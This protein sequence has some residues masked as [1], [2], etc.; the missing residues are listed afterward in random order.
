MPLYLLVALQVHLQPLKSRRTC[1]HSLVLAAYYLSRMMT[2]TSLQEQGMSNSRAA[3]EVWEGTG[4]DAYTAVIHHLNLSI[5]RVE[6]LQGAPRSLSPAHSQMLTPTCSLSESHVFTL[7]CSLPFAH[8]QLLTLT[9]SSSNAHSHLLTLNC[10]FPTA[11]S[12]MR[13][14]N[15]SLSTHVDVKA[16]AVRPAAAV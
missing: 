12:Q 2:P 7:A 4:P 10:S 11:H 15:C 3:I 13:A 5:H 6:T 16:A 14:L 8:S 1:G 9:C